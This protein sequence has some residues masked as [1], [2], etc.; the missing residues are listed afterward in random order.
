[1]QAARIFS[2]ASCGGLAGYLISRCSTSTATPSSSMF[3]SK[4]EVA[5]YSVL[6]TRLSREGK[7]ETITGKP[8]GSEALVDPAGLPYVSGQSP[9]KEAGAASGVIYRWLGVND[10]PQ[11]VR[12][13]IKRATDAKF[14]KYDENKSVVHVVGPDFRQESKDNRSGLETLA[15][16]YT[17]ILSETAR[18]Q[19]SSLRLLP[20]SGGV[21]AAHFRNDIHF[22]T[23]HALV[24]GFKNLS[25]EEQESILKMDSLKMCIFMEKELDDF[26]RAR[27][28]ITLSHGSSSKL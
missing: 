12:D 15:R 6:G 17:N 2:V 27:E 22:M 14:H 3:L 28:W 20:V 7:F 21:F 11:D 16:A 26:E 24:Q 5:P 18:S 23:W 10:F 8:E 1:M 13:G 25:K 19:V 4:V 9:M